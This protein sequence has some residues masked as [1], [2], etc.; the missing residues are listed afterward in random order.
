MTKKRKFWM[1]LL[2]VGLLTAGIS[3]LRAVDT[4]S[5]TWAAED[6]LGRTLP[7]EDMAPAPRDGK[8]VG[9][10]YY[11]WHGAHNGPMPA[12][13]GIV[14]IDQVDPNCPYDNSLILLDPPGQRKWGPRHAYHHWGQSLYGYYVADDEWV[15]RHNAQLLADAGVDV[16]IFDVTNALHY[17]DIY[18]NLLRIYADIRAHGGKTP[19]VSFLTN[20]GHADVVNALYRDLYSKGLY[21]DLWFYW[22]GKPLM[23]SKEDGLSDEVKNFFTLRRSWAWSKDGDGDKWFKDGHDAWPWLDHTPQA[24][25]WHESPDKP[26][27]IVVSTAEHP[28][29]DRG[30]S[31]HDGSNPKPHRTELG[32]YFAEQWK[33]ALEVDPEFVFVTQWNEWIAMRFVHND[34][35]FWKEYAGER[36]SDPEGIFVDV[37][38]MEYNRDIEPMTGG[39]G[40]NYYYQL[41]SNIRKFK[42]VR[43]LPE[44]SANK[45]ANWKAENWDDVLPLYND[46]QGDTFHRNHRAYGPKLGTYVN[47]S[48]RN[49]IVRSKVA[50]AGKKIYFMAET[51]EPLTKEIDSKWMNL[52]LTVE[53]TKQPQWHG[54]Q[55]RVTVDAKGKTALFHSYSAET[56]SNWQ[57]TGKGSC[58]IKNN[59]I[60]IGLPV[61]LLQAKDGEKLRLRF[62]WSDNMQNENNPI[63]WIINGDAAPNGR[64]LY[65]WVE[66]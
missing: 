59:R 9:V 24:Y 64:A 21:K 63:D 54:I 5:D 28:N 39:F 11:I 47:D 58:T 16:I 10:F 43:P 36:L 51:A 45:P 31:F 3:D 14:P 34:I 44:A 53:N 2:T 8:Y 38:N 48:G 40:D 62:K 23:M 6:A 27:Q 7:L 12:G 33:R 26:E 65:R 35:P 1:S 17:H 46:D 42:G 19:A 55:S 52:W 13:Q 61:S 25:G 32:L 49:D 50:R 18:M 29:S 60:V 57:Q 15:I 30:K 41:C 56:A 37:Y 22:K 20:T 66:K 4:M